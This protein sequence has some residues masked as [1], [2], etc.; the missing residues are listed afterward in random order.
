MAKIFIAFFNAIPQEDHLSNA[1]P[2]FYEAFIKELSELGNDL[3]VVHHNKFFGDYG[4]L[5]FELKKEIKQFSPDFALIFN[6]SFFDLSKDFDFPIYIYEV[7]SFKY[8][9]NIDILKEKKD[10]FKYIVPQTSSIALLNNYLGIRK[11]NILYLP[12]FTAVRKETLPKVMNISFIGTR[13]Y[14]EDEKGQS[15]WSRF[16]QTVPSPYSIKLYKEA[17]QIINKDPFI[18]EEELNNKTYQTDTN[19]KKFINRDQLIDILSGCNR[20]LTLSEISDLGLTIFG[21]RSWATENCIDYNIPLAFNFKKVY[22]LKHNQDIYNSSKIAIN[23]NHLQAK[24]GFS[25]R[26]C[27]IMASDACLVSEY[28]PDFDKLFPNIPIPVF[29]DRYTAR[30][31]CKKLLEN[32]N[33]RQDIISYCNE[34][35][36]E[37]FRFKHIISDLEMFVG[38]SLRTNDKKCTPRLRFFDCQQA[39]RT[40]LFMKK[41]VKLMGALFLLSLSQL[42]G[43][44]IVLSRKKQKWL[45]EKINQHWT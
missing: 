30:K 7:D 2:C 27:D 38:L 6:N 23:I 22:S 29:S 43:M 5:P 33:M 40:S 45:L 18:S 13:F 15:V 28:K 34:I 3:F 20:I 21:T 11:E 4:P 32:S 37:K 9:S 35:I 10:R 19:L 12:F 39:E 24:N 1:V 42:P 16:M 25:W 41:K 44:H 26:V 36:E 8:Y 31:L 14:T 17:L